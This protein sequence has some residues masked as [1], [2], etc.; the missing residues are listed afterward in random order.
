MSYYET[1]ETNDLTEVKEMPP[2]IYGRR[3]ELLA[4][5][6][7]MVTARNKHLFETPINER[8]AQ[9]RQEI[10]DLHPKNIK[11]FC[12]AGKNRSSLLTEILTDRG[13]EA[14]NSGVG[15]ATPFTEADFQKQYDVIIFA[16]TTEEQAFHKRCELLNLQDLVVNI[17]TRSLNLHERGE[18]YLDSENKQIKLNKM[19]ED[20]EKDLDV[21]G[22]IDK[23]E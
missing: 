9:R 20:L 7:Q 6:G 1:L 5:Y 2:A 16:S 4:K 10:I 13:Y 17:P 23:K 3:E 15:G 14:D 8:D 18:F 12:T 22:F 19:R 11:I 21:L